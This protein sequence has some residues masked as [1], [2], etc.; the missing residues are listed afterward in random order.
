MFLEYAAWVSDDICFESFERELAGLPGAYAPPG[1][2]LLVAM[3]D[4]QFA[5]C[6]AFRKLGPEVAEM[7]RLYVR[8]AFRGLGLGRGLTLRA[9]EEATRAGFQFLRL[10][11][12]PRMAS[13]LSLY[14]EL[15]FREIP[16]Y[17]DH[18]A[19]ALCF[20]LDLRT[21]PGQTRRAQCG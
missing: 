19:E 4:G 16:R 5:G 10:D 6:V 13:A 17:G 2:G 12:L 1:G 7:K 8:P 18:P 20:E 14:R 9:A 21:A 3:V 11:S 15:G